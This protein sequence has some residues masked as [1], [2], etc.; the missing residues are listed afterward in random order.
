MI[1]IPLSPDRFAHPKTG[2][3]AEAM[4]FPCP[5]HIAWEKRQKKPCKKIE[6]Y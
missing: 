6:D 4:A 5:A 3:Q 1:C 2:K